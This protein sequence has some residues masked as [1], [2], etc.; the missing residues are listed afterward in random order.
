MSYQS[1]CPV[2]KDLIKRNNNS[3][4]NINY[5]MSRFNF[6]LK[7]IKNNEEL[8]DKLQFYHNSILLELNNSLR[9]HFKVIEFLD[10]INKR[11]DEKI[12]NYI[13]E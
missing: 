9:S 11:H 5:L 7:E 12:N 2:I 4:L 6:N 1:N 3:N 10:S 8:V 13:K